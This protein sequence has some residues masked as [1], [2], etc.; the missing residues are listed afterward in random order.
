MKR[1][2]ALFFAVLAVVAIAVAQDMIINVGDGG[3]N[4]NPATATIT[5]GSIITFKWAIFK[6]TANKSKLWF[7]CGVPGHCEAGMKLA[8]TVR[9]VTDKLYQEIGNVDLPAIGR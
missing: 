2:I 3:L 1:I 7:M 5:A 6:V 4:F 9:N 8:L